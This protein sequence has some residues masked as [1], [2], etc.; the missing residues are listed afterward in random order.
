MFW[1]HSVVFSIVFFSSG[2][3]GRDVQTS[4]PCVFFMF[5]LFWMHSVVFFNVCWGSGRTAL[6]F[7]MF[8]CVLDVA[9]AT[10]RHHSLVFLMVFFC[11]GRGGRDVQTSQPCVFYRFFGGL[12]VAAATSRHHS[13]VF[14]K[15][16]FCSGRGGR[17][18]QTS[19]PCV[20]DSIR[21]DWIDLIDSID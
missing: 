8:F 9:A 2:R 20:F 10:S 5:F 19:Q 1:T 13:L 15:V 12:V 16:F 3:R 7:C 4:E 11:S 14:L 6:C 18:V 21:F 17:D